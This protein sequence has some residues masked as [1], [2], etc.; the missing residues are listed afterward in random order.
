MNTYKPVEDVVAFILNL[1]SWRDWS[2]NKRTRL[3]DRPETHVTEGA[4]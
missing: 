2:E 1:W 3:T 4:D